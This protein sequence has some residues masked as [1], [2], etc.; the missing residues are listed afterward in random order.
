MGKE[1]RR[2]VRFGQASVIV[3]NRGGK[4]APH[5]NDGFRQL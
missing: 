2:D 1:P 4:L 5:L 3:R